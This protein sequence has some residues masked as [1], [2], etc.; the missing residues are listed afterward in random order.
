MLPQPDAFIDFF[1]Y[2]RW[3]DELQLSAAQ[4][5]ADE[6]Y[7]KDHGFSFGSIHGV[8]LHMLSAQEVWRQRFAG[9]PTTWLADRADLRRDR[10]A[11]A[12]E[13]AGVHD[14]FAAFLTAQTAQSLAGTISFKNLKGQ[15]FSA[16]LWRLL[17]HVCNHS[18]IHRGQLNSMLKLSGADSTPAVDYSTWWY[19]QQ[20]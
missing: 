17:T 13:W 12:R 15:P 8:M 9:E 5:L 7:F 14:R 19:A 11:L 20:G 1:R 10:E 4:A 6:A 2:V 3:A 18:T 16:P